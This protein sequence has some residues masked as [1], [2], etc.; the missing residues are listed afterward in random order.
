LSTLTNDEFHPELKWDN[1]SG[2]HDRND[3]TL[4]RIVEAVSLVG[5]PQ[6]RPQ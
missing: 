4:E 6:S 5:A 1:P 3:E 2:D